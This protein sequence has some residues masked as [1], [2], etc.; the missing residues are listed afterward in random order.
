MSENSVSRGRP[1][2]AG[3]SRLAVRNTW[4]TKTVYRDI[5]Y[6]NKTL[7]ECIITETL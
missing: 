5:E 3:K 7:F 1:Y 2:F 4:T 6:K